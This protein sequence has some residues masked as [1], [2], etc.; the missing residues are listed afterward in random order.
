MHIL[1]HNEM[2]KNKNED[3]FN[4]II[5]KAISESEKFSCKNILIMNNC[6][7]NSYTLEMIKDK[8]TSFHLNE[9]EEI[10]ITQ[11]SFDLEPNFK[12]GKELDVLDNFD[13][14]FDVQKQPEISNNYYWDM[15][16]EK[17]KAKKC[18]IY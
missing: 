9:K 16:N 14:I 18:L 12:D 15:K 2:N 5:C 13:I 11:K 1:V 3:D 7:I 10:E 17:Q 6:E 4:Y 8:N